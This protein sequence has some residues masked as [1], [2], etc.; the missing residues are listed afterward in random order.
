MKIYLVGF[1]AS[2][3]TWLGQWLAERLGM[4]FYDLDQL[5]EERSGKTIQEIFEQAGE[6]HF[7]EL[8][9][10]ALLSTASLDRCIIATG[11]GTPCFFSNMDFMNRHGVTLFLNTPVEVLK[12]RLLGSENRPL[13]KGMNEET[14]CR[15]IEKKLEERMPFYHQSQLCL[16]THDHSDEKLESLIDQLKRFL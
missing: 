2:G 13:V 7:R 4:P 8:E 6:Q 3:K 15:F 1:M 14:L 11:G 12:T 9:K 5:I 16:Q 10:E